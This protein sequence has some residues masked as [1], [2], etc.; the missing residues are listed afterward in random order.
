MLCENARPGKKGIFLLIFCTAAMLLLFTQMKAECNGGAGTFICNAANNTCDG[1][2]CN[3]A[4]EEDYAEPAGGT[5]DVQENADHA[6]A[7]IV[8]DLVNAER[9]ACGLPPLY[10]SQELL[11]A[12]AVR[13][14]EI[15]QLFSHTRPNGESCTDFI[16]HGRGTVG[17]NIAA[18]AAT[19]EDVVEMWMNSPGHRANILNS[20][21]EELG[22]GYVYAADSEYLHYWVQLFRGSK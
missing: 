17:E 18:G 12:S 15:T 7:Q 2:V 21:Y 1:D 11:D 14:V 4:V 22:V 6:Y 8:L 3:I 5:A 9:K 19:P 13:A 10:L 16:F 20:D